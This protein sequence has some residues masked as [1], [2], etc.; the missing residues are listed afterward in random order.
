[1]LQ[2]TLAQAESRVAAADQLIQDAN[3]KVIERQDGAHVN[4]MPATVMMT[5]Q[6][7]TNEQGQATGDPIRILTYFIDYGNFIYVFHGMSSQADFNSYVGTFKKTMTKFD[8]LTDASKINK[9]PKTIKI[10]KV[11]Q[12]GPLKTVITSFGTKAAD[13][14]STA[15]LNGMEL[16]ENVSSG[17]VIKIIADPNF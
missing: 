3:L 11:Q 10:V 5:E 15:I 1:M 2:F 14:E 16:T 8:E 17:S 4:G 9:K 6:T 13:L 7:P 12:G